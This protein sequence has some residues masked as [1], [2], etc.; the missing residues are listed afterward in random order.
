MAGLLDQLPQYQNVPV[1]VDKL[2]SVHADLRY[3][4]VR[5][6]LGA[7]DEEK[8]RKASASLR[9]DYVNS[10]M[11]L[12]AHGTFDAGFALPLGHS[13]VWVRSAAGFSPQAAEE[14]FANFYFG[15]FGNNWVDH[16]EEKRYRQFSSF[17]GQ[18]LNAIG[19]RNFVRALVE[20]ALPPVRFSRAGTPDAYL[21]WMRP[22]IFAGLLATNLDRDDLRRRAATVGGQLDFRF[23]IISV[24]DMT[25]HQ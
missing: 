11:F 14:P 6:S 1:V 8:G 10:S 7:V 9:G 15:G 22:A 17:P 16:G 12:R 2:F 3:S 21:T 23:T 5:S 20:W 13:S 19:G 25:P 24:L 18:E 4:N